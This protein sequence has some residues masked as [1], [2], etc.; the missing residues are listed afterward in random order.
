[1]PDFKYNKSVLNKDDMDIILAGIQGLSSIDDSAK[2]KTL[3]A[4]LRFSNS[5]K[6]LLENDIVI[7]FSSWN[8]NSTIIDKIRRIRVAIANHK[9]L[10][11]K[12]HRNLLRYYPLLSASNRCY[13][14]GFQSG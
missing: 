13:F 11:M 10:N 9:F 7:D 12:Y 1:M 2:I 6:M 8:H 14:N 4:K 5:N 3:L